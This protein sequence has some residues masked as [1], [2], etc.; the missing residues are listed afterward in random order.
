MGTSSSRS[1]APAASPFAYTTARERMAPRALARAG[2][3]TAYLSVRFADGKTA[4]DLFLD[5]AP[6]APLA[7]PA[8][9]V[10]SAT[11]QISGTGA[12]RTL[13][14]LPAPAEE[15][16]AGEAADA[17]SHFLGLDAPITRDSIVVV[18]VVIDGEE[19]KYSNF[20]ASLFAWRD[21]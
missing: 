19:V 11:V 5:A 10:T 9:A 4:L 21:I 8:A 18:T 1:A 7:L 3:G 12:V 17:A 16:P 15:R 13:A 6:G 2:G 14:L 20:I